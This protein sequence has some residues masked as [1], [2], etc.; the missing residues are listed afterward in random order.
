[1]TGTVAQFS[2]LT[3]C[4]FFEVVDW[5]RYELVNGELQEQPTLSFEGS[6]IAAR[7]AA[8]LMSFVTEHNL[9]L[10]ATSDATF[11]CFPDDEDK[12]RRPDVSFTKKGRI[13]FEQFKRGHCRVAP[14]IAVEVISPTDIYAMVDSK[15][16]DYLGAGVELVW[17]IN[18]DTKVINVWPRSGTPK[19]LHVGDQLTG[20]HV[21]PGFSV[22]VED[23]FPRP[24]EIL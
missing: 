11:Q 21:L 5:E 18:P 13:P 8:Q 14:D 15:V 9:G 22:A 20:E 19:R 24:D 12:I 7:I 6:V 17:V 23:L 3:A 4:D 1:M 2:R 16:E 10:V